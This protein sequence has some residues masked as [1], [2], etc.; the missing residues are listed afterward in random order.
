MIARLA[1]EEVVDDEI[2][3]VPR[4]ERRGTVA[5]VEVEVSIGPSEA[6]EA[7]QDERKPVQ[8]ERAEVRGMNV[9]S[10]AC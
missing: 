1:K 7:Q 10:N 3:E 8:I 9:A 6:S 4:R 2:E 5:G